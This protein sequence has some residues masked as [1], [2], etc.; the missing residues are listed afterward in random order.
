MANYLHKCIVF[1]ITDNVV[2]VDVAQN[3]LDK[4]DFETNFKAIAKKIDSLF[5][6]ETTFEVIKTYAQF[7]AIVDGATI[8]WAEVKYTENDG[9]YRLYLLRDTL[10]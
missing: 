1:K 10:L 6:A 9:G 5:I 2:E 3:S 7:K 8:T 4:A